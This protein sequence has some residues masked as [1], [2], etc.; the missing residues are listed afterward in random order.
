MRLVGA[1][2]TVGVV[3]LAGGFSLCQF[4]A[5]ADGLTDGLGEGLGDSLARFGSRE[6]KGSFESTE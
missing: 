4:C 2:A 5:G 6:A 1:G 3:S